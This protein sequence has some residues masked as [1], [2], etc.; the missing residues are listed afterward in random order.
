MTEVAQ[1]KH[2]RVPRYFPVPESVQLSAKRGLQLLQ[3]RGKS[4]PAGAKRGLQLSRNRPVSLRTVARVAGYFGR[5]SG[6]QPRADGQ[7]GRPLSSR[8]VSWQLWGGDAGRRWALALVA[9]IRQIAPDL[10]RRAREKPP[11]PRLDKDQKRSSFF[12]CE[13]DCLLVF[14]T[15][16]ARHQFQ[17]RLIRLLSGS[18]RIFVVRLLP[19][20][21]PDDVA[22]WLLQ[23]RDLG[24]IAAPEGPRWA[25][26]SGGW[27]A[28][29][30]RE[31][32]DEQCPIQ[33]LW[34]DEDSYLHGSVIH[35]TIVVMP[36][37]G[38]GFNPGCLPMLAKKYF[39]TMPPRR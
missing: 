16:A 4:L 10:L 2:P 11:R 23:S 12:Q 7:E 35:G 31:S 1:K 19:G 18:Q 5:H 6:A 8:F 3:R 22:A 17:S 28:W 13:G 30:S 26:F 32:G 34:F 36:T 24:A 37:T 14:P 27:A 39:R 25:G 9:R 20:E 38:S 21:S 33:P 15:R 29:C